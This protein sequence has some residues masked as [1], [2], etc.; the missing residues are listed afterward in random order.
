MKA[1]KLLDTA[2][3]CHIDEDQDCDIILACLELVASDIRDLF[4]LFH[5]KLL[6]V[7]KEEK[8][9]DLFLGWEVTEVRAILVHLKEFY[10]SR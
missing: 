4:K 10:S 1:V 3:K 7:L 9:G 2:L 5:A 6:W 8:D